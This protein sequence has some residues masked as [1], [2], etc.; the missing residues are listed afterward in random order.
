MSYFCYITQH[1]IVN[2][3]QTEIDYPAIFCMHGAGVCLQVCVSVSVKSTKSGEIE[4]EELVVVWDRMKKEETDNVLF[5]A[6]VYTG[7]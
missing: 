2:I 4:S 5:R 1:S 6:S 3:L 7:Q